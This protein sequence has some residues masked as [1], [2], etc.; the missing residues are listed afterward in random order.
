MTQTA[1]PTD[2]LFTVHDVTSWTERHIAALAAG[3]C[4]AVRIPAFLAPSDCTAVL[5]VL[6]RLPVTQYNPDRVPV[7]IARFGPALNDH[8]LP[9]G[10][11]ATARYWHAADTA[12]RTWAETGLRPDPM[13]VAL[14]AIGTAWGSAVV[15][16]TVDGR[17]AFGGTIRE[18]NDGALIHC[19]EVLR[20]YPNPVFDQHLVA[21]LA[22]NLW[23][24]V[25]EIGGDTT[26]WRRRW[27]PSD[28]AHRDSYGYHPTVVEN[29]Q[30]V[31]LRPQLG[32]ALLFNP[33][34]MHAVTP[35]KGGRRIAFA[36]FL[37]LTTNG[38]LVA[39]S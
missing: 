6:D 36:C 27:Q 30:R 24:S 16:A 29:T 32:D 35:S 13:A 7:R 4:A 10:D 17:P 39:W 14:A 28:E 9:G 5:D 11:L 21:Q 3:T 19:D 37:G 33:T 25:P 22:L 12:R 23:V 34:H 26:I 2:P 31:T 20:E 18:I 8:R 1:L 15:P 38:Q